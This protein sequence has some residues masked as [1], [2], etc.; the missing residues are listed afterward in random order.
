MCGRKKAIR[1]L[2]ALSSLSVLAALGCG[3]YSP[4]APSNETPI[5]PGIEN[6]VFATL[7]SASK[8]SDAAMRSSMVSMVISAEKGGVIS[9][10][11]YSVCFAPG[12]LEKDTEISIEM[13]EFPKA[14]VKLGPHGIQF[15]EAVVLSLS[16]EMMEAAGGSFNVLWYNE[17][18]G[19]WESIGGYMED[20]AVKA[21]LKHFSEYGVY[22]GG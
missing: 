5:M 1:I 11:Y 18:T 16:K 14:I 3:S 7:L 4:V 19:L 13:P 9:N 15:K 2:A 22:D 17:Q 12:A 20:G 6:P 8:G 10:G 21:Q